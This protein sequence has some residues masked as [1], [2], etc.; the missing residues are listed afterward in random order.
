MIDLNGRDIDNTGFT[1]MEDLR[2]VSDDEFYNNVLE[3]FT[4]WLKN[5][6]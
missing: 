4:E 6:N 5:I 2:N 3:Q 1:K